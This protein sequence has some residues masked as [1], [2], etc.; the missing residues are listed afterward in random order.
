VQPRQAERRGEQPGGLQRQVRPR[1]I[2]A[3]HEQGEAFQR[4][5]VKAEL[6]QYGV[7]GAALAAMAPEDALDV[8]WHG[9]ETIGHGGNFAGG[10]EQEHRVAVDEA[11]DQPGAGDSIDFRPRAPDP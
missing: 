1:G 11:A 7:E 6:G 2:R 5:R 4:R 8:E 3:A 9:T 10:D